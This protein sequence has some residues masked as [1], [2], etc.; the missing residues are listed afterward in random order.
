MGT[1][2]PKNGAPIFRWIGIAF[3]TD[4]TPFRG[5]STALPRARDPLLLIDGTPFTKGWGPL[6]GGMGYPFPEGWEPLCLWMAT[7]EYEH[8]QRER[9]P[10]A[11]VAPMR[12]A[13]ERL[14]DP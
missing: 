8:F 1:H 12:R 2:F 10:H 14:P 11:V 9:Y 5:M 7:A 3:P 6:Y 4:G 13:A